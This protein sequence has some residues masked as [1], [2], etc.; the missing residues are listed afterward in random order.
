MFLLTSAFSN[1]RYLPLDI[2]P[3][4]RRH[5]TSHCTV[6]E[7]TV[8]VTLAEADGSPIEGAAIHTHTDMDHAGMIS[9]EVE[10]SR[11]DAGTYPYP[12]DLDQGQW[13]KCG[14]QDHT[15]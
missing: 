11:G 15:A 2:F 3:H 8:I 10:S 14:S 4:W 12:A 13:L 7:P 9:V 6:D 5:R 1:L